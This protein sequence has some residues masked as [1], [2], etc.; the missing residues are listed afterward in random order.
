M[1]HI[2]R[3]LHIQTNVH[4]LRPLQPSALHSIAFSNPNHSNS[5]LKINAFPHFHIHLNILFLSSREAVQ[6]K[7][8]LKGPQDT[9]PLSIDRFLTSCQS[10]TGCIDTPLLNEYRENNALWKLP[11]QSLFSNTIGQVHAPTAWIL[12]HQWTWRFRRTIHFV[13]SSITT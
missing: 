3:S 13:L 5:S 1:H 8:K 2:Q 7:N 12:R 11:M 9:I 4:P 10:Q 6:W